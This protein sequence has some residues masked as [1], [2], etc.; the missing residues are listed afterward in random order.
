M[1]ALYGDASEF[2]REQA[3]AV[4]AQLA[5]EIVVLREQ[6]LALWGQRRAAAALAAG[7]RVQQGKAQLPLGVL[8]DRPRLGVCHA[9][10]HGRG[11]QRMKLLHAVQQRGDARAEALLLSEQAHRYVVV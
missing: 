10:R 9:H 5:A 11:A 6:A 2:F 1:A 7:A 8:R 4:I 3:V